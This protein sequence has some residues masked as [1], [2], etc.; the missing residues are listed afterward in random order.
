MSQLR[1]WAAQAAVVDIQA[2]D[3][4]LDL[5]KLVTAK[6]GF[7]LSLN[8][9]RTDPRLEAWNLGNHCP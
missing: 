7:E 9:V 6:P 8:P 3:T 5:L 2:V 1:G 4:Y